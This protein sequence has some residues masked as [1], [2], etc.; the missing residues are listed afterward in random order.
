MSATV[1]AQVSDSFDLEAAYLN[2]ELAAQVRAAIEQLAP[3][4]RTVLSMY[5]LEEMSIGEI[6][7]IAGLPEGTIKSHLFRARASYARGCR[8]W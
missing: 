8:R 5:H 7:A 1:L 6:A 3:V 2:A 4:Q